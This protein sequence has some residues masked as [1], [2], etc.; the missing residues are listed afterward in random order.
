M[1]NAA[2]LKQQAAVLETKRQ[3]EKALALYSQLLEMYGD[4][5]EV[6]VALRNR[7]G[8]LHLRVGN[9]DQ[10]IALFERSAEEYALSGFLNNAIALCNK[11]LRHRPGHV[12]TLRRLARYCAEKGLVLDAQR[13]YLAVAESLERQGQHAEALKA[14]GEFADVSPD[15][16]HVRTVV[17]EQLLRAGRREDALPHLTVLHRLHASAGRSDEA[18]AVAV[19]AREI[20]AAWEAEVGHDGGSRPQAPAPSAGLVFLDS[21]SDFEALAPLTPAAPG[22]DATAVSGLELDASPGDAAGV[23]RPEGFETTSFETDLVHEAPAL[24]GA[25]TVEFV[26]MDDATLPSLDLPAYVD[27][28][29]A[30]HESY[31]E[32]APL[33]AFDLDEAPAGSPIGGHGGGAGLPGFGTIDVD[34]F[35]SPPAGAPLA[36][37]ASRSGDFVNLADLLG[38]EEPRDSRMTVGEPVRSGDEDADL[39]RVLKEFRAGIEQTIAHD[40][41]EAHYDLGIAF[42]EMGLLD[43]AIA[44]FQVALRSPARRLEAT[45]ALGGCFMDRGDAAI[46]R[47]VLQ[48]GLQGHGASD[49][50]LRGVLYLLGRSE[51]ALGARD[52]ALRYYQRVYAV[53]IRF[54]DVAARLQTLQQPT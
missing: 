33:P 48:Q 20:D 18:Q 13:H 46:A 14:L 5:E 15:D 42:R 34:D 37:A 36:P 27:D 30:V 38:D 54:R 49:D 7:V 40:D 29:P 47:T 31:G 12:P 52:E 1:S 21:D 22:Q 23:A 24:G 10:A 17:V 8:D 45:E 32:V 19:V 50:V 39:Q 25:A 26:D 53:D 51:E 9:V 11:I 6:D 43:D 4:A 28:A 16:V 41:A 2:T 44:E 35:L 3:P